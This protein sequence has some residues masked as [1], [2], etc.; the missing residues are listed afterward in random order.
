[1]SQEK[2]NKYKEQKVNRK[3]MM[4]KAKRAE[5]IRNCVASVVLVAVIAW[6]GYSGV[7]YIIKHQPRPEVDVNYTS[8][9]DYVEGLAAEDTTTEDV[10]TEE[11]T[12]EDA[13]E[14]TE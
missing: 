6:V 7:T 10:V 9:A 5:L 1:M 13:V 3:E 11:T 2:V 12:T 8:V 4:K 14:V